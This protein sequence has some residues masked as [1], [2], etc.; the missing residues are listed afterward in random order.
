MYG[1]N[2]GHSL[3]VQPKRGLSHVPSS[4]P[5]WRAIQTQVGLRA[6]QQPV[7]NPLVSWRYLPCTSGLRDPPEVFHA[8]ELS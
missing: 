4:L 3:L 8:A 2:W 6:L 5:M 1:T 7:S